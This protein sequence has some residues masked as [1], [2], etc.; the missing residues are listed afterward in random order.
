[1]KFAIASNCVVGQADVTSFMADVN[2]G[3][4]EFN[5]K[6]TGYTQ[7]M[8]PTCVGH[9]F[10]MEGT[11]QD[12]FSF[13]QIMGE[14]MAPAKGIKLTDDSLEPVAGVFRTIEESELVQH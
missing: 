4:L 5:V 9:V 13:M 8:C 6:V 1:M 7:M 3:A 11:D 12:C 14:S 10:L 2:K